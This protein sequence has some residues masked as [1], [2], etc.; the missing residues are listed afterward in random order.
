LEI[1]EGSQRYVVPLAIPVQL[2]GRSGG[3]AIFCDTI[4]RPEQIGGWQSINL[5]PGLLRSAPG[6]C[7]TTVQGAL[8]RLK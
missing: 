4:I 8:Q 7:L 1:G 5:A 6:T 3:L 2:A